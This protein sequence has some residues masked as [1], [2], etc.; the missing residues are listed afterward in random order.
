MS[1]PAP[2]PKPPPI[3]APAA[4]CPTAAPMRPPAAAPPR[5]PIPAALSRVVRGPPAQP[6]IASVPANKS[7]GALRISFCFMFMFIASPSQL[8]RL[9]AFFR[10]SCLRE[11][12]MRSEEH[13]S[14]LQSHVNLVCRLLLEKKKKNTIRHPPSTKKK[15][16]HKQH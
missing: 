11:G 7:T 10:A 16:K 8:A 9:T 3:A 13:T 15:E 14:E 2:S 4:G 5:T 6:T 1:A 12:A